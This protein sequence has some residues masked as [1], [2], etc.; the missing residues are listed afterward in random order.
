MRLGGPLPESGAPIAPRRG[1]GRDA[2]MTFAF[3]AGGMP[4]AFAITLVTSRYLLPEGRGAFV[5]ALLSVTIAATLLGNVGVAATHELARREHDAKRVVAQALAVTLALGI[6]GTAVLFPVD[7][8]L[9]DHGFRRVALVAFGLPA[10]LVVQTLAASLVALGRL[11]LANVLQFLLPVT[12]VATMFVFVVVADRGATGAVVAWVI[13]QSILACV[14]LI[15]TRE[16]WWPPSLRSLP[17]ARGLSM[18]RLGLQFGVVNLIS[19]LNYRIELIIL[20]LRHGLAAV[21][22]YSLAA[23]M[24]ELLWVVSSALATA[25]VAPA[26]SGDDRAAAEVVARAIRGALIGT[27]IL[28]ACLAVAG[29]FLVTP[30]FGENFEPSIRPLL[31]LVPAMVAFAPGSMV[32][33]Y[34]SM[35]QGRTRYPL[36]ISLVS[37][38]VTTISALILIPRHFISGAAE[39]CAAGYVAGMVAGLYWF[40]RESGLGAAS[41]VPRPADLRTLALVLRGLLPRG[42]R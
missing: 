17:R 19:L 31:I 35:R 32:G 40:T 20:E 42:S 37:L 3:R 16:L 22:L 41:L 1:L 8:A 36:M 28:G 25:T 18:F 34:F 39:A 11:L 6:V 24:A 33:V 4:F 12:T 2:L 7:Y 26:V 30:V 5:L 9:A 38:A 23:S 14:A 15:S 21:G 29:V 10:V 13:A 27:A